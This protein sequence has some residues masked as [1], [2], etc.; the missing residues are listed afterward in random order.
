VTEIA[1]TSFSARLIDVTAGSKHEEEV[2]E[3]PR[4]DLN[5]ADE[6]VLKIGAV[7]RWAVG[8]ETFRG[9]TKRRVS[10]I[11]FRRLPIWRE[12]DLET[13]Q[14]GARELAG[15]LEWD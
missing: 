3:L 13:A 5:A 2:V 7:F 10:E 8:Y 12:R 4:S 6:Q 1:S 15:R 11:M 14:K 9:G